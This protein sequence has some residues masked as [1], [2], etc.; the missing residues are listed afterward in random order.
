MHK[1]DGRRI[2]AVAV[3]AVAMIT[4]G[5]AMTLSERGVSERGMSERGV[6]ERGAGPQASEDRRPRTPAGG[7]QTA[8][9]VRKI[10]AAANLAVPHGWRP[11]DIREERHDEVPVTV[12][13]YERDGRRSLGGE[14]VSAVVADDGTLLGYT[15]LVA[16][17]PPARLSEERARQA[18]LGW[19][20]SYVPEYA[21][22]LRVQWVDRH[23]E[24]VRTPDGRERVV[25]G[26]KVKAHHTSGRYAWVIVD[27]GGRI[28]TYERD[29]RWDGAAGRRGT[30]MWL[31]DSWIAAREGTGPQPGAPYAV[32]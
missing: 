26:M 21:Q 13:R 17:T 19:L 7:G 18:A 6:S 3:A 11:A 22:G 28:V 14:H 4:G 1:K 15:R 32:A 2:A 31:H 23:D 29:V 12:V 16:D 24:R 25:S 10:L 20:R 30:E 8:E 27:G 5:T 9:A